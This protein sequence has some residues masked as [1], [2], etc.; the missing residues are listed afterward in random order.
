MVI[1]G[2]VGVVGTLLAPVVAERMRRRGAHRDR[3]ADQRLLV[4][5]DVVRVGRRSLTTPRHGRPSPLLTYRK[6]PEA[7]ST[8]SSPGYVWWQATE[9]YTLWRV[10][11]GSHP[12]QQ[13]AGARGATA[14]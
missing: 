10:Q 3:L 5:A 9:C 7:N 11:H 4:Y 2:V 6:R 14:P 13:G 8:P 1:V 12:V